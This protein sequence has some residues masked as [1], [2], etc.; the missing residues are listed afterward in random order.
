MPT[1]LDPNESDTPNQSDQ[2]DTPNQPD[3]DLST[4]EPAWTDEELSRAFGEEP[5]DEPPV[6]PDTT[7]APDAP[8]ALDT[9]DAPDSPPASDPSDPSDP[10]EGVGLSTSPGASPDADTIEIG[11]QLYRR[12]DVEAQLAWASSLTPEQVQSIAAALDQRHEQSQQSPPTQPVQQYDPEDSIDPQLARYVNERLAA[13]QAEIEQL[14]AYRE[15]SVQSQQSQR[16][17]QLTDGYN[18]ARAQLAERYGFDEND[19]ATLE[20]QMERTGIVGTYATQILDA[21]EMFT[22]AYEDTL[23]TTPEF[24][25]QMIAFQTRSEAEERAN[26]E[27]EQ[28]RIEREARARNAAKLSGGGGSAPRTPS[29]PDLSTSQARRDAFTEGIAAA[30]RG[31]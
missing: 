1:E 30:L 19:M 24:R 8:D 17:A 12:A 13:Q 3:I 11:G 27:A 25:A 6:E 16:V 21:T 22:R 29:A 28:A 7:D 18:T 23:W 31:E 20:A 2:P 15:Q 4:S 10:S 5:D 14:A 9:T 26:I